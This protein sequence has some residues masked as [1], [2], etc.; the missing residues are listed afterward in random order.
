MNTKIIELQIGDKDLIFN[1]TLEA[2]NQCVNAIQ[3]NNKVAPM[4][5]FL[6]SVAAN[7]S[8]KEAVKQAYQDALTSDL[9]GALVKE[10]KPDVEITVKKS[11]AVPGKSN[12]KDT[13]S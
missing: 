2:Y 3:M 8:T 7:D 12:M 9:F 11:K 13:P 10:F 4:Q 5:N 1:V 6:M